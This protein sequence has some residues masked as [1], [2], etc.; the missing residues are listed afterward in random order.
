VGRS[1]GWVKKWVK[2]LREAPEDDISVLFGLPR[3]R[4]TPSPQLDPLVEECI[5]AI[6]E[7]PPEHLHWVPG[8]KAILYYLARDAEVL[9]H[10]VPLPRSTR[11]IWKVLRRHGCIV[12]P[13]RLPPQPMERPARLSAWQIDAAGCFD[14]ASR[15][16]WQA[17]ARSR[18]LACGRYGH[19]HRP[20]LGGAR[21]FSCADGTT[22]DGQHPA[23]AGKAAL[24]HL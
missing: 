18:N 14:R 15:S 13:I 6:R 10:A 17:A 21:Q 1:L 16:P 3:G 22:G 24:D 23:T 12:R 8:P 9:E 11:T 19:L 2:R 5:L 7:S 20:R 4:R